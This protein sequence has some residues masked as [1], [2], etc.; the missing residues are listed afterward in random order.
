MKIPYITE[1]KVNY[2]YLAP[3]TSEIRRLTTKDH[4]HGGDM[5]HCILPPGKTSIAAKHKSVEELWY[6]ISGL[7]QK[8]LYRSRANGNILCNYCN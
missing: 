7:G 6:F 2:D 5:A 1:K 4:A 8:K 3:D